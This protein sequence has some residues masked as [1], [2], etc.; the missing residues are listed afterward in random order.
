[1]E[2]VRTFAMKTSSKKAMNDWKEKIRKS[3]EIKRA[4]KAD[5]EIL[6][7]RLQKEL[8]TKGTYVL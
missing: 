7:N 8:D 1:M 3:I 5:A 4:A 6:L 2:K